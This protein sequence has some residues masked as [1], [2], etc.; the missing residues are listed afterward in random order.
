MKIGTTLRT[1]IESDYAE[2]NDIFAT[3]QDS[4]KRAL[5]IR[6]GGY[7]ENFATHRRGTWT[8]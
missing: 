5:N 2:L 4:Q 6:T 8:H 1:Q 7:G 3:V